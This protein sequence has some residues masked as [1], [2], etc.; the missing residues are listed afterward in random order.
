MKTKFAISFIVSMLIALVV[1]QIVGQ[2]ISI[3]PLPVF[4]T[5]SLVSLLPLQSQGI[6]GAGVYKEIW[7]GELLNKFRQSATFLNR[8]QA[9]DELVNNNVIHMVDV[10]A[11]PDVLINNTTYPISVVQRTDSDLAIALDKYDTKNTKVTRD[12]LYAI[13]YDKMSSILE[14][15]RLVLDEKVADKAAHALAP[16]ADST[17]TPVIETTGA[18]NGAANARLRLTPNDIIIAKRKLDDL[19]IP[20][21]NRILV[22]CNQHIEDL[23]MVDEKFR[24]QYKNIQAGTIFNMYGFEIHEYVA[25]PVYRVSGGILTKKSFGAASAT[26]DQEASFFFYAPRAFK[27]TGTVEMFYK[28]AF[29]NPEYRESVVGFRIYSICLPKKSEG[30]GAIVSDTV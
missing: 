14:Q 21:M 10:G 30:F 6:L 9:R 5:L 7:T 28:D 26:T 22:L 23:L 24:E 29:Q 4:G 18:S 8:I 11:D 17:G 3:N 12:E 25:C 27:A 20:K 15:H 2:A 13:S 16:N 19:K 1:S